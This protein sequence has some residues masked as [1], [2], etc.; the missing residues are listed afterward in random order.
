MTTERGL[1]R[2]PESFVPQRTSVI[3]LLNRLELQRQSLHF[4]SRLL[5]IVLGPDRPF[6]RLRPS[7]AWERRISDQVR[8]YW[9]RWL[10]SNPTRRGH[11]GRVL[12]RLAVVGGRL[13]GEGVDGGLGW[14]TCFKVQLSQRLCIASAIPIDY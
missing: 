2:S 5:N 3:L 11:G 9:D 10:G 14:K 1:V 8:D 4:E 7:G 12:G 13:R 6:A